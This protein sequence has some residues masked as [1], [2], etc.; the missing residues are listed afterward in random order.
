[1]EEASNVSEYEKAVLKE[2]QADY[3]ANPSGEATWAEVE[4]RLRRRS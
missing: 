1:L 4:A 2:A 3:E